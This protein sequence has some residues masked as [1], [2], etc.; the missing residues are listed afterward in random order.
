MR[1]SILNPDY[2]YLMK[3][4][5][6]TLM[7]VFLLQAL[8]S[9]AAEKETGKEVAGEWDEGAPALVNYKKIGEDRVAGLVAFSYIGDGLFDD[10]VESLSKQLGE[11]WKLKSSDRESA[12]FHEVD[13]EK[14]KLGVAI[15]E[16]PLPESGQYLIVITI[17]K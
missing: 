9:C 15:D 11:D 8:S 2:Y 12:L 1:K 14:R 13:G 4:G 7:T 5:I 3:I 16:S 6:R 17:F 10:V